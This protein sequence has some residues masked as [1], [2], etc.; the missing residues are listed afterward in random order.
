MTSFHVFA[1]GAFF[2]IDYGAMLAALI[3]HF[4]AGMLSRRDAADSRRC[5]RSTR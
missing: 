4:V 1:I 3:L 2:L 5:A